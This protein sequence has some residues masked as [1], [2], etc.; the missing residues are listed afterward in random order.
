MT[1]TIS[2]IRA[3]VMTGVDQ[4]RQAAHLLEELGRPSESL[5]LEAR[6]VSTAVPP[7]LA[8]IL[9]QVLEAVASGGAVTVMPMPEELTT[10]AAAEQLGISR[11]TL[12][13]MIRDGA[14]PAHKV[15]THH[16]VRSADIRAF[17]QERLA[18]QRRALEELMALEDDA[19]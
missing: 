11:P 1:D 6:D 7:P 16:R 8:A 2:S 13:R 3:T 18:R 10:T 19:P 14:L 4:R 15:G 12:M 5:T 9:R 17:K